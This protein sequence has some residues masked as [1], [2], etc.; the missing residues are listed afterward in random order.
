MTRQ[1]QVAHASAIEAI[2]RKQ[3]AGATLV[4]QGVRVMGLYGQ[5]RP[6]RCAIRSPLRTC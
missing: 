6:A 2:L 5:Q 1:T 3:L 4:M